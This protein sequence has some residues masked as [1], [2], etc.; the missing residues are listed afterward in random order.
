[1]L[2]SYAV[3][4]GSLVA[5][6]RSVQGQSDRCR[7]EDRGGWAAPDH[8]KLQ[9][10]GYLGLLAVGVGY[11]ALQMIDVDGYYGWV[12]GA[13]N[14]PS[15]HALG[16]RASG[17]VKGWCITSKARWIYFSLGVTALATFGRGFFLGSPEPFPR[18]YYP[19]TAVRPLFTV[20]NELSIRQS[21]NGPFAAHGAIVE[22][23]TVDQY[24]LEWLDNTDVIEPL[25][26][27]SLSLGYKASF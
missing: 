12:P 1:M 9:T 24:F 13:S 19:V 17:H 5:M 10:G 11:S 23:T 4:L 16:L 22:I 21:G 8:A 27:W 2:R 6:P 26:V 7:T 15:I 25:D 3:L 20:G 18:R 14:G